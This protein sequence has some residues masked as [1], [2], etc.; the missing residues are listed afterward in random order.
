VGVLKRAIRRGTIDGKIVPV[1]GGAAFKNKGVRLLLD[2]V[3]DY[4]PSPVDVPPVEGK[5]PYTWEP[6]SRKPDVEEPFSALAFKIMTDPYV[7]KLTFFRIYSGTVHAGDTVYNANQ[8]RR[9][10]I[11]R[12]VEMH[13]N[14]REEREMM[15]AGDIAAAVG[16][17]GVRTGDSLCDVERPIV[18]ESMHFP[19]P[20]VAVAIEPKTKPDE[21]RLSTALSKLSEEDPTFQV[22][23]DAET[24]QTIISGMGELHLEILVDRMKR[25]F[26]VGATVGRPQVAFKETI[27]VAVEHRTR[28]VKQTG[29]RGQFA[30]VTLRV[31]PNAPGKGFEFT[32]RVVG[33]AIPREYIPSVEHGVVDAATSGVLAGYPVID[34]K[35]ELLDGTY[36]EVDSSDM[37]F[38]VAGS[39]AFQEAVRKAGPRLL[40]PVMDVEVVMPEEYMGDVIGDLSSRRGRIGGMFMRG[41]GRVVAAHVPLV[42]MFG[43]ATHLRSITQGRGIYSMQFARYETM[44]QAMADE[45]VEKVQGR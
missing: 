17:K 7:G 6:E 10:R 32:S 39:M 14:K 5:S 2:A 45:V 42:E 22:R 19:E 29:G 18:L 40:E 43:Y 16:L 23:A 44:P 27:T 26:N 33:G 15:G 35:V 1:L 30:D 34:V 9:E 20:V 11:G 4:L 25:E 13:A 28:F 31:G 41:D 24:G 36:H 38:R 21:E 3:C 8:E 37:A 12:I